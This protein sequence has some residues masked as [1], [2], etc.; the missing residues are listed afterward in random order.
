MKLLVLSLLVLIQISGSARATQSHQ[1]YGIPEIPPGMF[2]NCADINPCV[3]SNYLYG[4]YF[5]FPHESPN[6]F[7]QCGNSNQCFVMNCPA[8]LVWSR[9]NQT[10]TRPNSN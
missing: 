1:G 7:V 9:I 4:L 10:C 8:S 3:K 5:Y 6:K 2:W